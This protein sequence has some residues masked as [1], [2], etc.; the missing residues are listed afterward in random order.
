M[1][2]V[3]FHSNAGWGQPVQGMQRELWTC[4]GE[5]EQKGVELK[6]VIGWCETTLNF[7]FVFSL[8]TLCVVHILN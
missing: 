7:T 8:V 4:E 6:V 1:Q 3:C 2:A 5:K